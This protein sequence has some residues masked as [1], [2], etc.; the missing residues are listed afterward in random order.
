MSDIEIKHLQNEIKKRDERIATLECMLHERCIYSQNGEDGITMLLFKKLGFFNGFYVEFG[1]E[2]GSQ[3]NSR[4]L[5]EACK[6]T[7]LLMDGSH[8]NPEINLKKEFLTAEN[9]VSLFEKH[10]VPMRFDYLSIDLDFNDWYIAKAI[11]DAFY[12]PRVIV[13]EYNGFHNWDEDKIVVYNPTYMWD[14]SNY[15]SASLLAYFN[16]MKKFGYSLIYCERK[17]INA[18]FVLDELVPML[19]DVFPFVGSIEKIYKVSESKPTITR[20]PLNRPYV[21]SADFL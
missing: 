7:G 21:S 13:V 11:L 18:F 16:L 2:D 9:I 1:T 3:C 10:D 12:R 17:G 8:E 20:D 19:D 14:G 5:R 15:A 6:C 4:I